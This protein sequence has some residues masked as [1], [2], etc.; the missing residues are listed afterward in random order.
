EH[1]CAGNSLLGNVRATTQLTTRAAPAFLSTEA[2][3]FSVSPVVITSSTTATLDPRSARVHWNA[4]RTLRRRSSKGRSIC[5][6][7]S[8]ARTQVELHFFRKQRAGNL[9]RLVVAAAAQAGGRE[10]NRDHAIHAGVRQASP[11]YAS[12]IFRQRKLA[13]KLE[14]MHQSV[15]GKLVGERGNGGV[16]LRRLGQAAPAKL[17]ARR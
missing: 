17:A 11:E 8:R 6:G 2:I 3:S 1:Q 15:G 16:V 10:R 13:A 12:E 7:V 9:D 14:R 5:A 4:P